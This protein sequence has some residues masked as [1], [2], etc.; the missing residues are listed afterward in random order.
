MPAVTRRNV[1]G[2]DLVA[3]KD[4]ETYQVMEAWRWF[5]MNQKHIDIIPLEL[6][7][8]VD[9]EKKTFRLM[10]INDERPIWIERRSRYN[11]IGEA[12][13]NNRFIL[14]YKL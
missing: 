3:V 8:R 1:L 10:S 13:K 11:K 5:K 12:R 7:R 2:T 6:A 4:N 9:L 14:L